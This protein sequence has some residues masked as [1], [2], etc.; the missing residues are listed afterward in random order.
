MRFLNISG[1]HFPLLLPLMQLEQN[2]DTSYETIEMAS[3]PLERIVR[4]D[5]YSINVGSESREIDLLL[6]NDGQD[7]VTMNFASILQEVNRR[8]AL[9]PLVIAAIHCGEDRRNEYGTVASA[10]YKGRGAKAP[11]YE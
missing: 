10:D 2:V 9:R 11:A 3:E 1:V 7:L 4:A 8:Q 5:I 6:I